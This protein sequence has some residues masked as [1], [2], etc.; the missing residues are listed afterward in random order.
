MQI[1]R[2]LSLMQVQMRDLEGFKETRNILLKNKP[3]QENS[4]SCAV[5]VLLD[6]IRPVL[7]PASAVCLHS[8][9]PKHLMFGL[10]L[11]HHHPT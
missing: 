7:T 10:S 8:V 5:M 6:V 2:D 1:L 11:P 3:A 4:V 9:H